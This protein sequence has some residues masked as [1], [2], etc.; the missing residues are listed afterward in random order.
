MKMFVLRAMIVTVLLL[1]L[2]FGAWGFYHEGEIHGRYLA[3]SELAPQLHEC[4]ERLSRQEES[5]SA[6][7]KALLDCI[8]GARFTEFNPI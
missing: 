1:E 3:E 7:D 8:D 5:A 2:A 6:C 4:R